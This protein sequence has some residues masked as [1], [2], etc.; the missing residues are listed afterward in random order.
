M[1]IPLPAPSGM[2][3]PLF[4]TLSVK[5]QPLF[6]TPSGMPQPLFSTLLGSLNVQ[7]TDHVS[8]P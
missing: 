6:S 4:S 7:Q 3:Q 5:P 1:Q 2:P 8:M